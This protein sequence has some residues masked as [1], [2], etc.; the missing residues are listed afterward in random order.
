MWC[1]SRHELNFAEIVFIAEA[2][3]LYGRDCINLNYGGEGGRKSKV[4]VAK[5]R[6]SLSE[7]F[8]TPKG[9]ALRERNRILQSNRILSDET[10][11]KISLAGTGK[12]R[13]DETRAK[14]GDIHR[15]R[16]R[17]QQ[18]RDN[19]VESWSKRAVVSCPHCPMTGVL[20]A[21][22]RWHFDH[23][24]VLTGISR[25]TEETK[26]RITETKRANP[27]LCPH[28][29]LTGVGGNM[30]RFHFDNCKKAG[31]LL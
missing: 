30:V 21:M 17:T 31:W 26:T 2:T 4:S 8:A 18:A 25:M 22:M 9:H 15:G 12:K 11:L 20:N 13:S 27:K 3:K 5:Q 14:I 7:F 6:K 1:Y 19:M 29:G 28:C 16:K 23:C 24:K 10:K